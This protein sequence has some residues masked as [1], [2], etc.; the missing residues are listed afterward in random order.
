[1]FEVNLKNVTEG[2]RGGDQLGF[3]FQLEGE[4]THSGPRTL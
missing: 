1:M 4:C 2:R 3:A